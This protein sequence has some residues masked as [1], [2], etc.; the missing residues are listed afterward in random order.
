MKLV[1]DDAT[2]MMPNEKGTYERVPYE[3]I[4][5]I[6]LKGKLIYLPQDSITTQLIKI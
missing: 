5:I 3:Q 6:I 2:L 1:P 4:I